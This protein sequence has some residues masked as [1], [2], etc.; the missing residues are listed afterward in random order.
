MRIDQVMIKEMMGQKEVGIYSA[1]VGL[2]EVFYVIPVM[3][4]Q[5]IYPSLVNAK[6]ISSDLYYLR[7]RKL[8]SVMARSSL[9][10][11][12]A[13]TFLSGW[14]VTTIYGDAYSEAGSVLALHIWAGVFVFLGVASGN[15]FLN[16]NLQR[17]SSINTTVGAVVNI[18]LNLI[19][20]PRYG[21]YGA[22]IATVVAYAVA[23]YLMNAMFKATRI[24]FYHL[25]CALTGWK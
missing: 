11:A 22:A 10:I 14:L 20:I 6:K 13:M 19:L 15:W 25:T 18:L 3:I 17:Y 1:A 16:E 5:S 4:C 21:I 2:S 8:Y 23:A 7:L 9:A 12:I 24:N